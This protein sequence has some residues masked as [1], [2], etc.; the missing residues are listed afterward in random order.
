MS[1]M[2]RY[3]CP[4]CGEIVLSTDAKGG[5]VQGKC[6]KCRKIRTFPLP[7]EGNGDRSDRNV[8]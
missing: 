4:V 5:T 1:G 3:C 6:Q 2:V 7:R 8:A